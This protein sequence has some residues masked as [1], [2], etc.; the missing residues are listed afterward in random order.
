M[1]KRSLLVHGTRHGYVNV[2]AVSNLLL[3][4]KQLGSYALPSPG[5]VLGWLLRVEL[6]DVLHTKAEEIRQ[7]LPVAPYIEN[8]ATFET[9]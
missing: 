1:P 4:M 9:G 3:G 2:M 5:R 7:L 8:L 6:L